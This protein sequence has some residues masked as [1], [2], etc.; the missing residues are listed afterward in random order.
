M[1]ILENVTRKF[2]S[3]TAVDN[4]SMTVS[5][6]EVLGF[7][8]PNGAGKTT[9]MRMISGF[10]MPSSG[11]IT[12]C[13]YNVVD[14]PV[15]VK[16]HIGYMP[17]VA[18][19]YNDMTVLSF[20]NFIAQARGLFGSAKEKA[21][22]RVISNIS[23]NNVLY[24]PIETLSKGYKRRVGLAQA[25]V[26]NPDILILDEPTEGLD[27]N[28]KRDIRSLIRRLQQDKAII[29][30]THVLEEVEAMC[31]RAVI[32]DKG[33]IVL[34]DTPRALLSLS[35]TH[36]TLFVLIP[37]YQKE[38]AETIFNEMRQIV[39]TDIKQETKDAFLFTIHPKEKTSVTADI[40]EALRRQDVKILDMFVEKGK[41]E[42]VFYA[43]TS[44]EREL[45]GPA[46]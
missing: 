2:G 34:D 1:I 20:L 33:K 44:A 46:Q 9:T 32:I 38:R 21:V 6:G 18:S 11:K 7:L 25:L 3:F 40:V 5:K 31:S 4:L 27:P 26:H 8:G 45:K 23:L 42:E 39:L 30:S 13:G 24:Q 17:E 12:V 29:I 35:E 16:R 22:E 43:F 41:L 28:Q 15:E 37:D 14:N 19:S 36:Q 10:L